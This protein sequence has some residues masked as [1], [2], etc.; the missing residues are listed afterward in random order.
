MAALSLSIDSIRPMNRWDYSRIQPGSV[1]SV[2]DTN[3][4]VRLKHSS[5]NM[6][7]RFDKTFSGNRERYLGSN[8]QNG[9]QKSF[10]SGNTFFLLVANC[11]VVV[12]LKQLIQIGVEEEILKQDMV[13]YFKISE[14]LILCIFFF[15]FFFY[16]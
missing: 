5:P 13:I 16:L 6:P 4:A 9:S 2:G 15:Y 8:V 10:D 3:V 1:G 7:L 11:K 12:L 14:L